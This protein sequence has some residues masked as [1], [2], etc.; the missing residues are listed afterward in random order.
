M[1]PLGPA[2]A[3]AFQTLRLEGLREAPAAFASSYEEE[4]EYPLSKVTGRLA[5]GAG[6]RVFGA[7]LH[8][9]LVGLVGLYREARPKTKHKAVVWGLYV[10]P[11]QR[12][13][14]LGRALLGAALEYAR[15]VP[16]ILQVQ[17]A[18]AATNEPALALYESCGFERYACEKRAL[19]V[20]GRGYDEVALALPLRPWGE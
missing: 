16:G 17:I 7:E 4:V 15:T 20:D 12:G 1:R 10:A 3:E 19:W 18:A 11:A 2:D 13:S 14:G 5:G 8:G 9:S 6:S